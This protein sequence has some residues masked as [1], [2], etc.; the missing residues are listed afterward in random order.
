TSIRTAQAHPT[1]VNRIS[2]GTSSRDGYERFSYQ[3]YVLEDWVAG[4]R[5]YGHLDL[6]TQARVDTA[7]QEM[8]DFVNLGW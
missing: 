5:Y 7:Y 8:K 2:Q 4:G 3:S 1:W 6:D